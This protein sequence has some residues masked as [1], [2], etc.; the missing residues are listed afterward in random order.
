MPNVRFSKPDT[1]IVATDGGM[2]SQ[3][4]GG[5]HEDGQHWSSESKDVPVSVGTGLK[6]AD[7]L[8]TKKETKARWLGASKSLTSILSDEM[9]MREDDTSHG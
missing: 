3:M 4:S 1:R 2:M 6:V 5:Y 8:C 9:R 7:G